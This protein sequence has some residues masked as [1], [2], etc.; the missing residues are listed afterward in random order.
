MPTQKRK[1]QKTDSDNENGLT[2]CSTEVDATPVENPKID[3][4]KSQIDTLR[5]QLDALIESQKISQTLGESANSVMKL[6]KEEIRSVVDQVDRNKTDLQ[7]KINS[8]D[9]GIC[10]KIDT[11]MT[12]QASQHDASKTN[13]S[14]THDAA[15]AAAMEMEERLNV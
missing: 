7:N 1:S 4:M 3:E 8:V 12:M 5:F 9:E 13:Q 14:K 10:K 11:V 2:Q 6:M 15:M